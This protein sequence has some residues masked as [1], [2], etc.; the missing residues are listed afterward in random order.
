MEQEFASG[1]AE[2]VHEADYER[3]LKTYVTAFDARE[4]Y[5]M[6]YRLRR[7]DG[8][9]RWIVVTG[10]P[11]YT[12]AGTFAGYIGSALDIT[13]H[14]RNEEELQRLAVRL[15]NLQEA[16]RRRL[17]RELHDVTAQNLFATTMNLARLQRGVLEPSEAA[18]LLT[19]SRQLCDQAL[20]EIRTLSYVLHPPMLDQAGLVGALKWYVEGFVKRSGIKVE[21]SSAK[22]IGRLSRDVETALFRVVQ[23]SL[24][25]IRRHSESSSAHIR[26]EKRYDQIILQ[27]TDYGRGMSK[28]LLIETNDAN[29]L[30]V[31]IPGMRQRLRQFGGTLQIESNDRG[32]VVT[33]RVPVK[34]GV[35]SQSA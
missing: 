30:G 21:V 20:Q 15:L 7:H 3:C 12:P 27:I 32:M 28:P 25:N 26:L 23:E 24:T 6:E 33:A 31:G 18:S 2:G 17:A 10:V 34:S 13:E 5:C 8:E 35:I 14:K 16:E 4:N 11:R 29:A 19:E 9:Y 22:D 1:W